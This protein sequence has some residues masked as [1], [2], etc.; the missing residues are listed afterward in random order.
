MD[1][2]SEI[3]KRA[4]FKPSEVCAIA[5]LQPYV[6]RS[7]EA[8]F[9]HLGVSKAPDAPRVYRRRDLE[10]VLRIKHLVFGEGLTL[11]AARRKLEAEER[12]AGDE[13]P[14]DELLGRD[15]RERLNQIKRGL[16]AILDLLSENGRPAEEAGGPAPAPV[17]PRSTPGLATARH[18]RKV[19]AASVKRKHTKP[20]VRGKI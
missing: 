20:G 12:P 7:W 3:P 2:A 5:K 14:F 13:A 6:L 10:R 16:W 18:S 9:P 19:S 4:L 17:V 8:E 15:V 1:A 11:G